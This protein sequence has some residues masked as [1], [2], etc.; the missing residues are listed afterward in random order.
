M[1]SRRS[2]GGIAPVS[3]TG[4]RG[5]E[6]RRF[7]QVKEDMSCGISSFALLNRDSKGKRHRADFRW[8]SA[9]VEDRARSSRE[10]RVPPL[11]PSE[12]RYVIVA[13]LLLLY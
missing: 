8:T 2:E 1:F 4:D 5:F 6:S 10:N 13:Y 3:G 11:R 7:D 12:R 9:T